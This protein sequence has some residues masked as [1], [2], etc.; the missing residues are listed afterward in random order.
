MDHQTKKQRS[1]PHSAVFDRRGQR[2]AQMEYGNPAYLRGQ[3]I[4]G[5]LASRRARSRLLEYLELCMWKNGDSELMET[6]END[7]K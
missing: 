5:A 7:E 1:D 4:K 6:N 3:L 2:R